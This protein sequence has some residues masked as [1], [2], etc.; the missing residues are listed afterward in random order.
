MPFLLFSDSIRV[1]ELG[2][3][4]DTTCITDGNTNRRQK[5]TIN[6]TITEHFDGFQYWAFFMGCS[7]SGKTRDEAFQK[8][9]GMKCEVAGI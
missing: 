8:A 4:V 3:V 9:Y 6:W 5:M 1:D 2:A 7:F